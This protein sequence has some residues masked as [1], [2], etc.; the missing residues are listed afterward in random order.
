MKRDI[1][2]LIDYDAIC[3][4]ETWPEHFVTDKYVRP[5]AVRYIE[6]FL[7]IPKDGGHRRSDA[8]LMLALDESDF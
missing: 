5:E 4:P 8:E 7:D 1:F 3:A 6:W 2:P